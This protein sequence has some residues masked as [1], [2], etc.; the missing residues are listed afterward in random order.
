[1]RMAPSRSGAIWWRTGPPRNPSRRAFRPAGRAGADCDRRL[2]C[3][4]RAHGRCWPRRRKA[5]ARDMQHPFDRT[6]EDL[7]NIVFL[8]HVNTCIA[9]QR[10]ATLFYVSGLGLTR[11]P[12]L[13]TGVDNM[14]ATV[15]RSQFH[16]PTGKPQVVRGRTGLVLP[17]REALL[18]RL[19]AVREPL[20][21]TA[22]SF[23]EHDDHV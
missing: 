1:R 10:L 6:T 19:A 20:R 15:G 3:P 17:D 2:P 5:G 4:C 18:A 22:F 16:L 23:Q 13:M 14:W 7:G 8:E 11:D 12:Y 21:D 9:D